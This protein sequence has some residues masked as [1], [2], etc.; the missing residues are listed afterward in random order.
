MRGTKTAAGPSV[1]R[2]RATSLR[3]L[4]ATLEVCT[5][6][7]ASSESS[8][9]LRPLSVPGADTRHSVRPQDG[10]MHRSRCSARN[11]AA[12]DPQ[13]PGMLERR[14]LAPDAAASED[15]C[16]LLLAAPQKELLGSQA[17][18]EALGEHDPQVSPNPDGFAGVATQTDHGTRR[19]EGLHPRSVPRR[20]NAHRPR[21]TIVVSPDG[22]MAPV[23][24]FSVV[25]LPDSVLRSG[26]AQH[27][28][29]LAHAPI[30][31]P[32]NA[33]TPAVPK[34]GPLPGALA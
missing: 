23:R 14:R 32:R 26:R 29:L 11:A 18:G 8:L 33:G 22:R 21:R 9:E 16:L 6:R 3:A 31:G 27:C 20:M 7:M 12:T 25:D 30:V 5:R 2:P 15:D 17:I 24:L 10:S 1:E 13:I 19:R 34:D 28:R 4:V